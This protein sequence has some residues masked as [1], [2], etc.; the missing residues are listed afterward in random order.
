MPYHILHF[1]VHKIMGRME[2]V[3]IGDRPPATVTQHVQFHFRN[4]SIDASLKPSVFPGEKATVSLEQQRAG[5]LM[6][7]IRGISRFIQVRLG[8][9]PFSFSD[10]LKKWKMEKEY[11]GTHLW[12]MRIVSIEPGIVRGVSI[13]RG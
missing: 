8:L 13:R 9:G 6:N 5:F 10:I 2:E 4:T 3:N 12:H 7:S 1:E 11:G